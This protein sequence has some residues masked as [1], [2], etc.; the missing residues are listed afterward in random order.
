MHALYSFDFLDTISRQLRE[1]L[2]ALPVTQLNLGT[3]VDLE[4]FQGRHGRTQGVYVVHYSGEPKYVGKA[5][6]LASRLG[7]HFRKLTGRRNIDPALIGYKCLVLDG[8]MSTAANEK[9]LIAQY[10]QDFTEM[11]NGRGFGPNDPG[12]HRDTTKP[13]FFDGEFPI[14]LDIALDG[15][16]DYPTLGELAD[17]IKCQLP[18]VFR[19]DLESRAHETIDLTGV[20]RL[21]N[22][23]LQAMVNQLGSGWRGAILSYGMV[24]YRNVKA[25]P[26]AN[27]VDP[28]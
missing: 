2:D 7:Q 13:S 4:A 15:I 17:A 8:S 25:Y 20:D 27:E 6:N 28:E 14:R 10:K 3:L 19:Y 1:H 5:D 11:W 23:L 26:Y 24:F 22:R 21:P 18:Y 16:P 9:L 12:K